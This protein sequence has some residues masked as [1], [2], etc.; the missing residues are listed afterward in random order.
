MKKKLLALLLA[1]VLVVGLLA[2][3][4][5]LAKFG[6]GGKEKPVDS[7]VG[8]WTAELDFTDAFKDDFQSTMDES[9]GEMG[10]Y[11]DLDKIFDLSKLDAVVTLDISFREAAIILDF[12]F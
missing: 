11:I 5:D 1:L 4:Q 9:M 10:D 6:I 12:N 7:V 2:G 8:D 3:C